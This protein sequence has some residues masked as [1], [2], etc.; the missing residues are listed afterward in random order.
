M[1][2]LC[3]NTQQHL[4]AYIDSE[5]SADKQ[6]EIDT[7]LHSC[8]H[9]RQ[10]MRDLQETDVLVRESISF[11]MPPEVD[12]AGVWE[13]MVKNVVF[14]TSWL[15]RLKDWASRPIVWL[16]AVVAAGATAALVFVL[17]LPQQQSI[18]QISRVESV[19]SRAGQVMVFQTAESSQPL[20]WIM[21]ENK[22]EA[23]S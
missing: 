1:D 23:S 18:G 15:Q 10:Y 11:E 22:K 20:I 14:R 6:L 7:H 17:P 4:T 2:D 13:A 16:P 3:K 5:I 9:C 19:S 12:L 8:H 21:P